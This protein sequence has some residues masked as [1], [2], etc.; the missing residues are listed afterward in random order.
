[1]TLGNRIRNR[2]S[3][4]I[5]HGHDSYHPETGEREVDL[6]G[7]EAESGREFPDGKSCVAESN[8]SL[9]E[10]SEFGARVAESLLVVLV[11]VSLL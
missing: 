11:D 8:E 2:S 4:R 9:A 10:R 5:H 7:V 6:V 3:R 1:L